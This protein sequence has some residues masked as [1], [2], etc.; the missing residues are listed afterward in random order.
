[1]VDIVT[2]IL[3]LLT[4]IAYAHGGMNLHKLSLRFFQIGIIALFGATLFDKPKRDAGELALPVSILL[5]LAIWNSC[6]HDFQPLDINAVCDL[7]YGVLGLTILVKYLGKPKECYK[8]IYWAVGINIAVMLFQK[9]GYTPITHFAHYG[10]Y[11]KCEGGIFGNISQLGMYIAL[12]LPFI[13][14]A[15]KWAFIALCAGIALCGKS[16]EFT[17]LIPAGLMLFFRTPKRIRYWVATLFLWVLIPFHKILWG[18]LLFRWNNVWRETI[19]MIFEKPITGWGLG[20]YYLTTAKEGFCSYL[21]FL[22]GV[23]LVGGL[24]WL[25]YVT[26]W[27]VKRFD[28]SVESI[29]LLT[30]LLLCLIEYPIDIPRL[31]FTIISVMAFFIIKKKEGAYEGSLHGT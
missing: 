9:I 29:S 25:I 1:M 30:F 17:V 10:S 14:I 13:W 22:F 26:R 31:W 19:D 20:V 6:I 4:P 21:P 8:Y 2:K 18:S 28:N 7:F 23:G 11:T 27:Y 24:A 3:L 15:S 16:G 5:G 12:A